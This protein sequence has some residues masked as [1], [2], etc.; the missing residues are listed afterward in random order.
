MT[1]TLKKD[2]RFSY[3]KHT[4]HN[5]WNVYFIDEMMALVMSEE[6]ARQVIYRKMNELGLECKYLT[7]DD[8]DEA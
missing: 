1:K 5:W 7:E 4:S 6:T 8:F 2:K 3:K